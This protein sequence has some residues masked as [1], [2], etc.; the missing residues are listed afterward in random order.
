MECMDPWLKKLLMSFTHAF[1]FKG[2]NAGALVYATS[3]LPTDG[4]GNRIATL[5]RDVNLVCGKVL[6]LSVPWNKSGGKNEP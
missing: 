6:R 4:M 3:K 1:L 2:K 5:S